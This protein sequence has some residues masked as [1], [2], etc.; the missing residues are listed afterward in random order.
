MTPTKNTITRGVAARLLTAAGAGGALVATLAIGAQLLPGSAGDAGLVVAQQ[1][2]A[3]AATYAVDPVHSMVM[4]RVSHLDVAYVY[5][6][7]W[8]TDGSFRI[9]MDDL[10]DSVI[11]IT[12]ETGSIDTG[13]DARD[14]HLKGGDFFDVRRHP[15]MAFTAESFERID[16]DTLRVT[17]PLTMLGQSREVT[18]EVTKVGERDTARGPKAGFEAEFTVKR[19][20]WGMTKYV[21]DEGGLGDEVTLNVTIEGNRQ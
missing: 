12:V 16:D 20:E 6:M 10:D 5:G 19:S 8:K 11:E 7:F 3:G 4:F 2:D 21:Q 13:N 18:A 17:G 14:T 9:D 15:E 1:A